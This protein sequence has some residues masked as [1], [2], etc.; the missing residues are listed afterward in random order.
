MNL[1]WIGNSGNWSGTTHWSDSSGGTAIGVVPTDVDDVFFDSS[2][3]SGAATV[4]LDTDGTCLGMDWTGASGTPGFVGTSTLTT[5]GTVQLIDAMTVSMGGTINFVG[6]T[7]SVDIRNHKMGVE[8]NIGTT[9]GNVTVTSNINLGTTGY[10]YT[11]DG[12]ISLNG[13]ITPLSFTMNAP[14]A[15]LSLNSSNI[16]TENFTEVIAGTLNL[17]SSYIQLV[18]TVNTFSVKSNTFGATSGSITCG[19]NNVTTTFAGADGIN[20]NIYNRIICPAGNFTFSN[21]SNLN[22]G[23]FSGG[24]I[25]G[26]VDGVGCGTMI[27]NALGTIGGAI[28]RGTIQGSVKLTGITF[29]TLTLGGSIQFPSDISLGSLTLLP[30]TMKFGGS[31]TLGE[32]T[33]SGTTDNLVYL[34]SL[35]QGSQY[36]FTMNTSGTKNINYVNVRDSKIVNGPFVA[37][38]EGYDQSNND[39]WIFSRNEFVNTQKP[40]VKT[41]ENIIPKGQV[42]QETRKGN[43]TN[44]IPK[45]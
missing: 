35:T 15:A 3:F 17:D 6:I 29:G 31:N 36:T 41:I 26:T 39:G 44:S 25:A 37:G 24:T 12:Q 18:G 1:Y 2:S 23:S 16:R 28:D 33:S 8:V 19:T 21:V 20:S 9:G 43:I 14:G 27:Y 42:Y 7:Q 32:M 10:L 30:G 34:R 45:I 5:S 11:N 22:Y 13:T 4:T 38:L 40:P